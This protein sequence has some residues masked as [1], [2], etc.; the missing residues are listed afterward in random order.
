V[1]IGPA[2]FVQRLAHRSRSKRAAKNCGPNEFAHRGPFDIVDGS[3]ITTVPLQL[4]I[5]AD[6]VTCCL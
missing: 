4:A 1:L 5:A 2:F 3:G 6:E